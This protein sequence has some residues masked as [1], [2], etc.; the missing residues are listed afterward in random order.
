MIL[1]NIHSNS[2]FNLD[3]NQGWNVVL[4]VEG[5]AR[6]TQDPENHNRVR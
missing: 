2:K 5:G 3:M 4:C 1:S 6:F